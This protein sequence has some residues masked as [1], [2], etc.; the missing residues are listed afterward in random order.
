MINIIVIARS[1]NND[2][3]VWE[4]PNTS[5]RQS[6]CECS[7][8]AVP[9]EGNMPPA[10]IGFETLPLDLHCSTLL[11][12]YSICPFVFLIIQTVIVSSNVN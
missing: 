3:K 8:H 9:P 12:I 10:W 5:F 2:W 7:D 6:V 4:D 11:D 1:Y